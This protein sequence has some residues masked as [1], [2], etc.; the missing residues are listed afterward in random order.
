MYAKRK[1]LQAVAAWKFHHVSLADGMRT[2][3]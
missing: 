1:N 3:R 2:P